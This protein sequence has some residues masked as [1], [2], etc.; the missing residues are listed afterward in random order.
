MSPTACRRCSPHASLLL[1]A[2]W[3]G[4]DTRDGDEADCK[5]LG[6]RDTHDGDDGE[7]KAVGRRDTRDGDDAISNHLPGVTS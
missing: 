5:S 6:C 4:H 1:P 3:A 2:G 7:C